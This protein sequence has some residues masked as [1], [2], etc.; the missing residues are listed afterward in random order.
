MIYCNDFDHVGQKADGTQVARVD[1]VDV[2]FPGTMPTDSTGI[3]ACP[4]AGEF[5]PMSTFM[6]TSTGD[7]KIKQTDGTWADQ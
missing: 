1:L 7:L 3:E 5:L 2:S 6:A 4:N